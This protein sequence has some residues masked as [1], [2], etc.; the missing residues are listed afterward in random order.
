MTINEFNSWYDCKRK[1]LEERTGMYEELH[2]VPAREINV[3]LRASKNIFP[4]GFEKFQI[5]S[6]NN[7]STTPIFHGMNFSDKKKKKREREIENARTSKK[8]TLER[9][10]KK[11]TV[12]KKRIENTFNRQVESW[13]VKR[14]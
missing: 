3:Q 4:G 5:G 6:F 12:T 2:V 14:L 13:V 8:S 9:G 11:I 7:K 10:K 1:N